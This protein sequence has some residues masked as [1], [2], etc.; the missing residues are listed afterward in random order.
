MISVQEATHTIL[1]S[2]PTL[3]T[4]TCPLTAAHNRTLYQT[5]IADRDLPPYDRIMMDGIALHSSVS[6]TSSK[7]PL[8]LKIAGHQPAGAPPQTLPNPQSCIEVATGAALPQGTD[9]IIPVEKITTTETHITI[10]P[11]AEINPGKYI[12]KQAS[13]HPNGTTLL[14]PGTRLS[15][16]EIAVA[17][18]AG[19]ISLEVA[20]VPQVALIS[21]GDELVPIEKTPL[22]HQIR[23]S[24]A[25][26]LSAALK[27]SQLGLPHIFHI[28]D[29]P[30]HLRQQIQDL[31]AEYDLLIFS[32]GV[33]KGKKDFLPQILNELKVEQKLHWV[34]QRPGK[35]LW[36]GTSSTHQPIF[37]LPGN[38]LSTLTCFHRYILPALEK[39]AGR[40]PL[41]PLHFPLASDFS[42]PPPLTCFL[43]VELVHTPEGT[44]AKPSPAHNSG[45]YSGI[46]GT[47]GFIE[48]PQ[49]E[50]E[51]KKGTAYQ[52]YPW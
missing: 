38:P 13:D 6:A 20:K 40:K 29:E 4:E 41:P 16:K 30:D 31:L 23:Q 50:K 37:A 48:I 14:H 8:T 42:F 32:G 12:H 28:P 46:L 5:I 33:S 49:Q 2:L 39:M 9:T 10:D 18:S 45:D 34:A 17:A 27:S 36:Y 52:F 15:A 35:P 25:H 11:D 1:E 51:A 24:N 22:P 26:T 47:S 7:E 3:S 44:Q 19:Y 43:P 21:T